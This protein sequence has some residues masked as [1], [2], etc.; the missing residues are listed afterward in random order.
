MPEL[1]W[2]HLHKQKSINKFFRQ[3][4]HIAIHKKTINALLGPQ[5]HN[6]YSF[7]KK[8][9]FDFTFTVWFMFKISHGLFILW[10][11]LKHYW[12]WLN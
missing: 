9:M 4:L 5:K 6:V 1:T 3:Q 10:A 11:V 7:E 2:L 8:S 12:Y